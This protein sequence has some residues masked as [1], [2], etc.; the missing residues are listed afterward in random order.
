MNGVETLSREEARKALKLIQQILNEETPQEESVPANIFNCELSPFQALTTY[1]HQQ[2]KTPKE[3]AR[4]LGR[5]KQFVEQ[6]IQDH[7]LPQTGQAL[8]INIFREELSVLEAAAHHLQQLGLTNKQIAA[9]LGKSPSTI[10]IT[11][12]RAQQKRGE[13]Q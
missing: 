10:W 13:K 9:Q 7:A 5:S 6:S 11:L 1:L 12:K 8:P 2:G 4:Q 3:I